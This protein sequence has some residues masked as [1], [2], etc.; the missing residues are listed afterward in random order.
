MQMRVFTIIIVMM[1][2]AA[3]VVLIRSPLTIVAS[4]LNGLFILPHGFHH[5]AAVTI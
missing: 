2:I 3:T 1:M 4:V 5:K